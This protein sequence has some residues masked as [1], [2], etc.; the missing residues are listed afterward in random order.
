[1]QMFLVDG[2]RIAFDN[3]PFECMINLSVPSSFYQPD[4]ACWLGCS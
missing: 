4:A 2:G 1:M 3:K